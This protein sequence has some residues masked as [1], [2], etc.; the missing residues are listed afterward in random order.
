MKGNASQ[1]KQKLNAFER[2]KRNA[3]RLLRLL[4]RR[5]LVLPLKRLRQ[6]AF[7]KKRRNVRRR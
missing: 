3:K 2:S 7:K 5:R 6:N 1:L 4:G